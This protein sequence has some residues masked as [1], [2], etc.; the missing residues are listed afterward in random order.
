MEPVGQSC[1]EK[2]PNEN[3]P[4]ML[5]VELVIACYLLRHK[6]CEDQG[7]ETYHCDQ[8]A[9]STPNNHALMLLAATKI[10]S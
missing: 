3:D 2:H 10:Y 5:L 6:L 4:S 1:G 9:E 7:G 8:K